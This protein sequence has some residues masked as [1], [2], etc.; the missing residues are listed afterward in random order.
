MLLLNS[1]TF[2]AKE[3]SGSCDIAGASEDT[4]NTTQPVTTVD[5]GAV[6]TEVMGEM[7][8]RINNKVAIYTC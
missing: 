6:K 7:Q 5:E 8:S 1:A 3:G 4:V 2:L